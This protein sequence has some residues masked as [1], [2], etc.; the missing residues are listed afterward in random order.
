MQG[1]QRDYRGPTGQLGQARDYRKLQRNYRGGR[2]C[3]DYRRLQG[4]CRRLQETTG[5]LGQAG[6]TRDYRKTTGG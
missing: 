2:V 1:L 3:R 4:D 6:A 5:Q